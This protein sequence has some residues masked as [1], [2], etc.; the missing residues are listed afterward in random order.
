MRDKLMVAFAELCRKSPR[1]RV[2]KPSPRDAGQ[3]LRARRTGGGTPPARPITA[4]R[5]YAPRKRAYHVAI[6]ETGLNRS[7]WN[8]L[9]IMQCARSPMQAGHVLPARR[10]RD[11]PRSARRCSA[12]R[13]ITRRSLAPAA[14]LRRKSGPVSSVL[15]A[16]VPKDET[17]E[18]RTVEITSRIAW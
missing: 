13:R 3:A 7:V 5:L 15:T 6:S 18:V 14:A 10:R 8:G 2:L 16:T 4:T 12:R 17:G 1:R 11:Y 9:E